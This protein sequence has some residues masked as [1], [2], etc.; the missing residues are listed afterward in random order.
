MF[1]LQ[2]GPIGKKNYTGVCGLGLVSSVRL[3]LIYG[4]YPD[5]SDLFHLNYKIY[6]TTLLVY[7]YFI[8]NI[9]MFIIAA[10]V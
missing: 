6:S 3:L 1:Y 9:Y 5:E 10:R 8:Y 2:I 7:V 4:F